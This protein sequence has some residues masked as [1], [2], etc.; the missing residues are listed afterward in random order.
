MATIGNTREMTCTDGSGPT[1]DVFNVDTLN[2]IAQILNGKTLAFYSD[3]YSTLTGQVKNG[4]YCAPR[5]GATGSAL[6]VTGAIATANLG[7]SRV[8]PTAAVTAATLATGTTD[9]QRVTVVN[10]SAYLVTFNTTPATAKLASAAGTETIATYT[11]ADFVWSATN[12]L[13]YRVKVA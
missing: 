5:S 11:A 7:I 8:L 2:G 12:S 3:A 10:E 1:G 9:G 6:A 4:V 13:W